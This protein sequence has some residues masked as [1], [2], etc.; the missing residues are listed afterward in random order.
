MQNDIRILR[1]LANQTIEIALSPKMQELKQLWLLHNIAKG[2]RPMITV[3]L[4]TFKQEVVPQ[5]LKCKD[6]E[7][8]QLEEQLYSGIV[9]HTIFGDDSIVNDFFAIRNA[10]TFTPFSIEVK[11]D[12]PNNPDSVGHHFVEVIKDLSDDFHMLKKSTFNVD[13]NVAKEKYEFIGNTIGDILPPKMVGGCLYNVLTQNLVH[14]MSMETMFTSMYDYPD[15][16]KEMMEMLS[17]DYIE[18][19][20]FLE[21]E[22]LILPTTASERVGQGTYSFTNELPIA[23]DKFTSKDVW[24]FMDS[25]EMVGTSPSMFE[26][27]IF[28]Y[29]RKIADECGLLS[30]GCCE[31]VDPIWDNCLSK[32]DNLRKVSISPWC[33]EEFM[34]EK[35]Q[36]TNIIYHRKPSPN[37][38]GVG[39][40]FDESAFKEHI[41]KTINAA[42]GCKVEFTQRDVYTINNDVDKVKNYVKIIREESENCYE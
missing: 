20:R 25:Q 29:Y 39:S 10:I 8:R 26:E 36:N 5:L 42:K 27:F 12:A 28:P 16:F 7:M 38:L 4:A 32:L 31:P 21:S 13:R 24:G 23:K 15:E 40:V 37:Y 14:I 34:G 6:E 41:R 30:Y 18:Y 22:D 35:L 2:K 11:K 9:N 3:E 17:N 1:D 19:F 33:N